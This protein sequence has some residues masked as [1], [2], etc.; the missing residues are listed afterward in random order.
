M[1]KIG[2]VNK[3]KTVNIIVFHT[4][5]HNITFLAV[6]TRKTDKQNL[7]FKRWEVK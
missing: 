1:L 5:H 2:M 4:W 6:I 3:L 7:F